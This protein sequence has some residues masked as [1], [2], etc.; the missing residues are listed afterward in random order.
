[1][2]KKRVLP[3]VY[4]FVDW[5]LSAIAWTLFY[6][7]RKTYE[8]VDANTWQRFGI[9]FHDPSFWSA[10]AIIPVCWVAFYGITGAYMSVYSKSRLKE[11]SQTFFITLLGVTVLFFVAILDDQIL[12]YK[13][14]Y[15]SFITLFALQFLLTYAGRLV[16]TS[17][18]KRHIKTGK[19]GFN[20]LIVGSGDNAMAIY[21]EIDE[22]EK[23]TGQRF[24]GYVR[25]GEKEH[26]TLEGLLP[27]LGSVDN[28]VDIVKEHEVEEVIIAIERS[29]KECMHHVL[30]V[31]NLTKPRWKSSPRCRTWCSAT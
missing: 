12:T 17:I 2:K 11:F 19:I 16:I 3:Y 9:A 28:I 31:M 13:T 27:C 6:Y 26:E 22:Q 21:K 23:P 15:Q 1:M 14:Y 8:V 20:T 7:F 30:P 29:E 25:V 5:I 18:V 4:G 24:V 10:V